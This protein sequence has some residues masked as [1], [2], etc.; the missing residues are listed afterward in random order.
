LRTIKDG[1]A[2]VNAIT[3]FGSG[4]LA[5]LCLDANVVLTAANWEETHLKCRRVIDARK[6][7]YW[8]LRSQG[9][10]SLGWNRDCA[11]VHSFRPAL[12]LGL[13]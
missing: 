4:L 8:A 3:D 11:V 12:K 6:Y 2:N 7:E 13:E 1:E 10:G 9:L 5:N